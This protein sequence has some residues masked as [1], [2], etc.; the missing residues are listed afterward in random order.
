V[1]RACP[2]SRSD[3][4]LRG[5]PNPTL[6]SSKVAPRTFP[7][8]DVRRTA[9][10]G[11]SPRSLRQIPKERRPVGDSCVL[12]AL[13]AKT[14]AGSPLYRCHLGIC[15]EAGRMRTG[16]TVFHPA[17]LKRKSPQPLASGPRDA[18]RRSAG[19]SL[20]RL[21]IPHPEG[22]T[23]SSFDHSACQCHHRNCNTR[24]DEVDAD[25]QP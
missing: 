14:G 23:D 15:F 19:D 24:C 9:D 10:L 21:K 25:N 5:T 11:A 22:S 4:T 16:N 18:Q 6:L 2:G 3:G 1:S 17:G 20:L 7:N 12:A 13:L 8:P